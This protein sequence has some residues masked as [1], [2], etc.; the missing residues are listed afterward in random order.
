MKY[1]SIIIGLG[2]LGLSACKESVA[3][4]DPSSSSNTSSSGQSSTI[5]ISSSSFT[6]S[7]SIASLPYTP[8]GYPQSVKVVS[9]DTSALILNTQVK[10][11]LA[12]WS[13]FSKAAFSLTFDDGLSSQTTYLKPILDKY[14]LKA[15]FFLIT[16]GLF[17]RNSE[18]KGRAGSW[19]QYAQ[20]Y[21]EGHELG[22]HTQTHSNLGSEDSLGLIY[23]L[24]SSAADLK[25]RFPSI[26]I[27]TMATP[28]CVNSSKI[29]KQMS[30]TYLANRDVGSV[31]SP[32]PSSLLRMGAQIFKYDSSRTLASDMAAINQMESSIQSD[33]IQYGKW[34]TLLAHEVLPFDTISKVTAYHPIST[35]SFDI[36]AK[37]LKEQNDSQ[38][39]W[40]APF[41]T[42]ARYLVQKTLTKYGVLQE[43]DVQ[44]TLL[45]NDGLDDK[46]FSQKI[47]IEITLPSSWSNATVTQGGKELDASI[48]N[49]KLRFSAL[50]STTNIILSKK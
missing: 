1:K 40:V 2:L 8:V 11:S 45:L 36:F 14:Q 6:S 43:N 5:E 9:V 39:L 22:A 47:A 17:E 20:F 21:A 30:H 48:V 50:P 44:I 49:S 46:E 33:I 27:P 26:G 7:S 38:N 19:E 29:Q 4:N 32:S 10:I 12:P 3:G 16:Q 15:T 13:N 18:I 41:G 24:D 23:A 25:R 37:W 31:G 28:Y 42:V 35:E 34:T